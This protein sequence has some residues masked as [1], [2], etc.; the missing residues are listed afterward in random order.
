MAKSKPTKQQVL[1]SLAPH[2]QTGRKPKKPPTVDGRLDQLIKD[3]EAW[4]RKIQEVWFAQDDPLI[5]DAVGATTQPNLADKYD[6]AIG[7]MRRI[8]AYAEVAEEKLQN[9]MRKAKKKLKDAA[10]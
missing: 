2:A 3:S 7:T 9:G 6:E 10:E 4:I 8:A 1:A 5:E